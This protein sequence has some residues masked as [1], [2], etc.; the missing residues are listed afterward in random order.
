[1]ALSPPSPG[2]FF[3]VGCPR[4]GTTLL[5]S[6]LASH[7]QVI[8]FP[9]SHF[10]VKTLPRLAWGRSWKPWI[11][12]L[13]RSTTAMAPKRMA[14]FLGKVNRPD[15][16]ATLPPAPWSQNQYAHLIN[17]VLADLMGQQHKQIW[18][19]KTP[20]HLHAIPQIQRLLPEAKFIHILRNG[21]DVVASLYEVRLKHPELWRKEKADRDRAVDRW[22]QDISLSYR[23]RHHPR[24]HLVRYE[25]LVR[26]TPG[27]IAP[28]CDFMGIPY[29]EQMLENYRHS[30]QQVVLAQETWKANVTQ[31]IVPTQSLKFNALF[32]ASEQAQIRDRLQGLA[33]D[34]SDPLFH[35]LRT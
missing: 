8:S 19:E 13:R 29:E 1:M 2:Q 7:S 12:W 11:L 24:H 33:I 27:T 20:D 23:Y 9:E 5:Q 4:S 35:N 16:A 32:S 3:L 26:D 18:L 21:S 6:L 15:L 30:S 17:A 31:A 34:D 28:L 22:I 25:Q 14:A 10:F